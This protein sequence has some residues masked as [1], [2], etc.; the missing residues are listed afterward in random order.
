MKDVPL[1]YEPVPDSRDKQ[2]FDMGDIGKSC[3]SARVL[4]SAHKSELTT[5]NGTVNEMSTNH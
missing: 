1:N 2:F 4:Y 3:R 5:P